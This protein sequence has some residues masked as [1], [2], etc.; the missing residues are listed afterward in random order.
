[1]KKALLSFLLAAG[2]T[3]SA[4]LVIRPT[5][6][7]GHI[8]LTPERV[9]PNEYNVTTVVETT[10]HA[11]ITYYSQALSVGIR[12]VPVRIGFDA[13]MRK[14]DRYYY[15][16]GLNWVPVNRVVNPIVVVPQ[17]PIRVYWDDHFFRPLPPSSPRHHHPI[18]PP[19]LLPSRWH[20]G[21]RPMSKP[22]H[23]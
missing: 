14:Y 16:S 20:H 15:L 12:Y 6:G 9:E 3:A 1:M 22:P 13:F 17:P 18:L 7:I 10:E 21:P 11:G 23:R 19:P 4:Q 5:V 8:E 2:L